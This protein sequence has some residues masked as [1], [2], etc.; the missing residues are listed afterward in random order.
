MES[1]RTGA[2]GGCVAESD[3]DVRDG[4]AHRPAR[5]APQSRAGH[6]A[7]I[8]RRRMRY[9][10]HVR[11]RR[12]GRRRAASHETAARWVS[13]LK[14]SA[15][16]VATIANRARGS[17][18]LRPSLHLTRFQDRDDQYCRYV[19]CIDARWRRIHQGT[20]ILGSEADR[21]IGRGIAQPILF[22]CILGTDQIQ[23][24]NLLIGKNDRPCIAPAKASTTASPWLRTSDRQAFPD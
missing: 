11:E 23:V 9:R 1:N 6:A 15:N 16:S 17:A 22:G 14:L 19:P 3:R 13:R 5:P 2:K 10:V 7:A 18:R 21:A 20:T 4:D 12:D 24:G 8:S